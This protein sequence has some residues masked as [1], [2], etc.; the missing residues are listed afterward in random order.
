MRLTASAPTTCLA[1]TGSCGHS[2]NFRCVRLPLEFYLASPTDALLFE[3]PYPLQSYSLCRMR[4]VCPHLLCRTP[5]HTSRLRRHLRPPRACSCVTSRFSYIS[6]VHVVAPAR[7]ALVGPVLVHAL[8]D[9]D[10]D[11]IPRAAVPRGVPAMAAPQRHL[12]LHHPTGSGL[13]VCPSFVSRRCGRQ[14]GRRK[15][16]NAEN[17]VRQ[18]GSF[19]QRQ[20]Y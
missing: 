11:R 2:N 7:R 6:S 9:F 4:R 17:N 18:I 1:C 10:G 12:P 15:A 5:R 3:P 14:D 13:R 16:N 8:G 20:V 19:C